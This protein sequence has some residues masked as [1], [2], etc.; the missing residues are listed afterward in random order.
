M[1]KKRL[2]AADYALI[3]LLFALVVCVAIWHWMRP[4]Q[5]TNPT[6]VWHCILQTQPMDATQAESTSSLP[7]V[8][9]PVYS[10]AGEALG[11]V[12]AVT[13]IPWQTVAVKNGQP[14]LTEQA[15]W[16]RLEVTVHLQLSD[17]PTIGAVRLAAGG[18]IDLILCRLFAAGCE[19]IS[20]EVEAD[21]E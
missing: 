16:Y 14:V 4:L 18:T 1:K 21:A 10:T 20:T 9:A 2:N 12:L 6:R 5:G 15:G 7:T 3:V 13:Q 17:P 19:I 8:G 11:T